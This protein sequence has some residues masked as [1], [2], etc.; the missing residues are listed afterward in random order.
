MK[1]LIVEITDLQF[2]ALEDIV[3]DPREWARGAVM[4]KVNKSI[5]K[6]AAKEQN[7]LLADP[8]VE[9]I[10]A[11]IDAILQSHFSQPDYKNRKQ[12]D[13]EELALMESVFGPENE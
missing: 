9:T 10:P 13:G 7:R 11:S 12:R 6:V 3:V 5:A 2:Q 1:R 8:A 4:G